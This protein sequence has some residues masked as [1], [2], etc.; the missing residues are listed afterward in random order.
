MS[1]DETTLFLGV[2]VN[3]SEGRM[4]DVSNVVSAAVVYVPTG[5]LSE[6]ALLAIKITFGILVPV[7][8]IVAGAF[9]A[10]AVYVRKMRKTKQEPA[11]AYKR[12]EA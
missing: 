4:S 9:I 12:R 6:Q 10:K 2:K 3:H 5:G 11:V 8:V 7:A 1:A